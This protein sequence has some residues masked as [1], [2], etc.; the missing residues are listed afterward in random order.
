[1][2]ADVSGH[3]GSPLF[4]SSGGT[5]ACGGGTVVPIGRP[6]LDPQLCPVRICRSRSCPQA[7][8]AVLSFVADLQDDPAVQVIWVSETL[9]RAGVT[10]LQQRLDKDWSLCDAVSFSSSPNTASAT[11]S[12]PTIT[13]NKPVLSDC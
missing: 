9:H 4:S 12:L 11:P 13:S 7:R 8:Q 2:A 5:A 6:A 1:M 10:H 3:V